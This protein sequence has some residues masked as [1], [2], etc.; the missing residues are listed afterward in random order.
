MTT[1]KYGILNNVGGKLNLLSD[2]VFIIYE[3]TIL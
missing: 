2:I 3:D 1:T